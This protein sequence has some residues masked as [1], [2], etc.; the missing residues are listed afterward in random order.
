[1]KSLLVLNLIVVSKSFNIWYR[2]LAPIALLIGLFLFPQFVTLYVVALLPLALVVSVSTV[3]TTEELKCRWGKYLPTLP[4]LPREV[5]ISRYVFCGLCAVSTVIIASIFGLLSAFFVGPFTPS[6]I[7]WL[8]LGGGVLGI[9]G[10]IIS[11]P[12]GYLFAGE[13]ARRGCP[14]GDIYRIDVIGYYAYDG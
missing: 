2:L 11:L 9:I 13:V 10:I 14:K 3:M 12:L 5:V 6:E 1:M 4:V 7:G 8:I